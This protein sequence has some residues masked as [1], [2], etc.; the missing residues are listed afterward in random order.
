MKNIRVVLEGDEYN[1]SKD[2]L[3]ENFMRFIS[4]FSTIRFMDLQH[5]NGSPLS[6]WLQNTPDDFH[7]Q[8]TPKGISMNLIAKIIQITGRNA[9][10]NVPHLASDDYINKFAAFLKTNIPLNRTIYVEYSN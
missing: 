10:I 1:F 4:Q 7:T 3:T 8:A 9:W 2:I 6:E 5:T